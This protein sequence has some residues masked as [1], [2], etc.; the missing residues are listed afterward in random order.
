LGVFG[1]HEQQQ[2]LARTRS[3][4]QQGAWRSMQR[5]RLRLRGRAW[6]PPAL[7]TC[8]LRWTTFIAAGDL[9]FVVAFLRD[10]GFGQ[11]RAGSV[12]DVCVSRC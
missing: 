1:P 5:E 11:A 4:D 3:V 2:L 9:S 10:N 12:R 6:L 7:L 8:P